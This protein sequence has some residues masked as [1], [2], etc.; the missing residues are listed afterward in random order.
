MQIA[1]GNIIPVGRKSDDNFHIDVNEDLDGWAGKSPL[2]ASFLIPAWILLQEPQKALFACGLQS[3]PHAIYAFVKVLGPELRIFET[4]LGDDHRLHVTKFMPH[5]SGHPV[6]V[7]GSNNSKSSSPSTEAAFLNTLSANIAAGGS[8]IVEMTCK[9]KFNSVHAKTK[10]SDKTSLVELSSHSP[11]VTEIVVGK[12]ITC[13]ARFPVPVSFSRSKLRVARKSFYIE[14]IAPI[15]HP[16]DGDAS[17][18]FMCP[19]SVMSRMTPKGA[20]LP[21]NWNVQYITLDILP[22][23]DTKNKSKMQWLNTH[24][25]L[26]M[27]S[28]ERRTR[29]AGMSNQAPSNLPQ[30][31]RVDFKDGVF[32][33]LMHFTGLQG[34]HAKVFALH[35]EGA[36]GVHVLLFVS[37]LKLDLANHTVVL[38]AAVLPLSHKILRDGMLQK[39]LGGLQATEKFCTINVTEKELKLWKQILPALA[40]RC[41]TWKHKPESCEYL[42]TCEIPPPK[43]L[44]DAN[45]PLCSCGDGVLP[46]KFM[47]DL[48]MAHLDYVLQK[49]ATR[50]AISPLFAVPYV[51]DC[52]L[53]DMPR[54][55]YRGRDSQ[56]QALGEGQRCNACGSDKKKASNGTS[57]ALLTCT[58][59]KAAKYCSK[60]C[61][62]ADWKDHKILCAPI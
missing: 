16:L 1:F 12:T 40:E 4:N 36:G 6:F 60:E 39:F 55:G 20:A 47:G 33:L 35:R 27:S 3:T 19:T 21:A 37:A 52:F 24:A 17:P 9:I 7:A 14:L 41:R 62:R 2:I 8:Q 61:Q 5:M 34:G 23:L 50:I 29:E 15:L 32:S 18:R 46:R 56:A 49:F 28:R 25:P 59:C 43:G 11:L 51:E 44:E 22:I 38:D 13:R 58:R 45:T 53:R 42:T 10:L 57:E 30:D 48:K 31:D 54:N 26:M